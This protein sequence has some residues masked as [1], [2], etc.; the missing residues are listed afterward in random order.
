MTS[1]AKLRKT[2]SKNQKGKKSMYVSLQKQTNKQTNK[3]TY[4]TGEIA[5]WLGALTALSRGPDFNSQQPH[6]GLQPSVKDLMPSSG[7]SG[8]TYSVVI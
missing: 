3:T 7:V 5:Q 2:V 4:R 6:G 8:N 1:R